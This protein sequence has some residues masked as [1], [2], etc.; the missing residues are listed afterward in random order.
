MRNGRFVLP[1]GD[2]GTPATPIRYTVGK[3]SG[4]SRVSNPRAPIRYLRPDTACSIELP[5][6]APAER[7]PGEFVARF[8]LGDARRFLGI[9]AWIS[10]ASLV[11]SGS[12]TKRRDQSRRR[13]GAGPRI[14]PA[15]RC[16][17]WGGKKVSRRHFDKLITPRV[18]GGRES[19]AIISRSC[20]GAA[21]ILTGSAN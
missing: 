11:A 13:I 6:Y 2:E 1:V 21:Y 15:G 9:L 16:V 19:R 7:Y 10:H 12:R 18:G 14:V 17:V 20:K 4:S 5:S 3:R 8:L